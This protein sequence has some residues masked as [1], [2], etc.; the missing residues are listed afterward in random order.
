MVVLA[1]LN[2]LISALDSIVAERGEDE[3]GD[4]N[5]LLWTWKENSGFMAQLRTLLDF[6]KVSEA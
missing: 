4:P 2:R 5:Y 6:G 3:N 1:G